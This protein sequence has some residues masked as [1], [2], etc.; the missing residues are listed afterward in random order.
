MVVAEGHIVPLG[1]S[2][3]V[4]IDQRSAVLRGTPLVSQAGQLAVQQKNV[5]RDRKST[6]L[7]SSHTVIS[8]AVFCLKKK[9]KTKDYNTRTTRIQGPPPTGKTRLTSHTPKVRNPTPRLSTSKRN[10]HSARLC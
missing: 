8:Y 5:D 6:R 2:E 9:K 7:N 10:H 3:V 4:L 1:W